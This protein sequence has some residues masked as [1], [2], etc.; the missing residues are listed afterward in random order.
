[1]LNIII[2]MKKFFIE[3]IFSTKKLFYKAFHPGNVNVTTIYSFIRKTVCD[4]IHTC[5]IE[6]RQLFQRL[7]RP[8]STCLKCKNRSF[9]YWR[10]KYVHIKLCAYNSVVNIYHTQLRC[11]DFVHAIFC[12]CKSFLVYKLVL[13]LILK[14]QTSMRQNQVLKFGN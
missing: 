13:F 9:I 12:P 5:W 4:N 8:K 10:I 11:K 6:S 3:V 1:M 2:F 7:F 14:V